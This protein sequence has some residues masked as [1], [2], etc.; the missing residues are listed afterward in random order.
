ML[1]MLVQLSVVGIWS[2]MF[3]TNTRRLLRLAQ[4]VS[5]DSLR[6]HPL[7]HRLNR[8]WWWLGREEFWRA[9]QFDCL[10]CVQLTLVLLMMAWGI[11]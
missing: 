5:I 11:R 10:H 8:V 7:R 4:A 1:A 9:V 6:N 3:V 2:A